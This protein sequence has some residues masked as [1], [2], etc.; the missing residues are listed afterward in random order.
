MEKAD[1]V[2]ILGKSFDKDD[3]IRIG[4]M[5]VASVAVVIVLFIFAFI[6]SNS[7]ESVRE[8]GLWDF[9]SGPVW[10]PSGDEF[11]A[12]PLISGTLLVTLGAIMFAL[13]L[14]L[15]AAVFISEIAPDRYRNILKP[16]CEVFS[17]IPSVVYGFFGLMVVIPFILNGIPGATQGESWLAGSFML[18]IMAL[19]TIITVSEDA[20][21]SVPWSYR[22]ASLAMGATRWETTIKVVVPAAV[23]GITAAIILGMGRA[24]GETMAVLMVTGNAAIVP[25]PI[26]NMLSPVRTMTAT[27][28]MEMSYVEVGSTHY[29]ALFFLALLLLVIVLIVNF[30]SNL[31]MR[32][33]RRK[34]GKDVRTRKKV[35]AKL[36][37]LKLWQMHSGKIKKGALLLLTFIALDSWLGLVY[38]SA[39]T[40]SLLVLLLGYTR[41]ASPHRQTISYAVLAMVMLV[42][43]S[44]LVI[45]LGHIFLRGLPVLS[46][47]FLTQYPRDAGLSGGI[48]PAIIGTIKLIIGTMV[49][50]LPL[51]IGA[52]I[53][54]GE[55]SKDSRGTRLLRAGI[56]NLNG[57]PSIVFGLFGFAAFVIYFG[58][59]YSLL[60]GCLTLAFLILPVLIRTTE[61]AVKTVPHELK[62][63]SL[64]LGASKWETVV[65]VILPTAFPGIITG[66]I[67][68]IGRAAG[69]T[70]PI[71]FTAV[72]AYQTRMG[73][74]ILDP[75]MALPYH[76]YYLAT[77][78]PNAQDQQYGTAV[79]LLLIVMSIFLVASIL[80]QH[81]SKK[82][83]W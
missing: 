65:K 59:G 76:L 11:G 1:R 29:S 26:W 31:V 32:R 33:T 21:N 18:G 17:G 54:L 66:S 49:I 53:Y 42:V 82:F 77:N 79:V 38:A 43:I 35:R 27:L 81:Y 63:A 80:R 16:V 83:K 8:V 15:G 47:D 36:P 52:G 4:L 3:L 9:I 48:Y 14:G 75:V 7:L 50:A 5:A 45:I 72:V 67:L 46:I 62:E 6:I 12:L 73:S 70:A 25:D 57:T 69:E 40:L 30:A 10:R 24:I 23:S 41:M 74:S 37:E 68:A 22:E 58:I 61:E 34:F 2:N 64:A 28:A 71:M 20:L 56:D 51:G 55:Y 60:A 78:V 39:V 19:P 13:P 44:L